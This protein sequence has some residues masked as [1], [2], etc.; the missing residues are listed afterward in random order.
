VDKD[1]VVFGWILLAAVSGAIL[2][3]ALSS[4]RSRGRVVVKVIC[5]TTLAVFL[6][7]AVGKHYLIDADVEL[8]AAVAFV[9]GCFGLNLAMILQRVITS[10]G[11]KLVRRV[12]GIFLRRP[13]KGRRRQPP[14]ASRSE[15]IRHGSRGTPADEGE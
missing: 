5:G 10:H 13:G 11:E 6:A 3:V 14:D 7:P 1:A 8:Q 12:I 4:E 9:V 2:P 15:Q